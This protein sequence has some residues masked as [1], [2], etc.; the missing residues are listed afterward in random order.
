MFVSAMRS[1]ATTK[2]LPLLWFQYHQ[3]FMWRFLGFWNSWY[4]VNTLSMIHW[5]SQS[6][7]QSPSPLASRLFSRKHS[8]S[9][10][11]V[12]NQW[13]ASIKPQEV[14]PQ[15]CDVPVSPSQLSASDYIIKLIVFESTTRKVQPHVQNNVTN[16][17]STN[18]TQLF[19]WQ[20]NNIS[21]TEVRCLKIWTV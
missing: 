16:V 21:N 19:Q 5:I 2:R 7:Q 14:L 20:Y 8:Y 10:Q 4:V 17:A 18:H 13:L 6:Q 12:M 1:T 15:L 11:L 9:S 3:P